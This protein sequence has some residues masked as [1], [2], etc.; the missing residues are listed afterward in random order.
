LRKDVHTR[1]G[2]YVSLENTDTRRYGGGSYKNRYYTP[3]I[4]RLSPIS[5]PNPTH[6]LV[7]PPFLLP[8]PLFPPSTSPSNPLPHH[9]SCNFK[10]RACTFLVIVGNG[11]KDGDF[12]LSCLAE[13]RKQR[14]AEKMSRVPP[15]FFILTQPPRPHLIH[16]YT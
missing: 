3:R 8:H 14:I 15:F 16:H 7:S 5:P 10:R 4:I 12:F 11:V 9:S 1:Y 13:N 6:S 2:I